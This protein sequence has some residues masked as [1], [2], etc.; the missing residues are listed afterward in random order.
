VCLGEA[1]AHTHAHTHKQTQV[2]PV[3]TEE[4]SSEV[5]RQCMSLYHASFVSAM[6]TFFFLTHK[7][8]F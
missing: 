4:M 1:R 6:T 2:S 7:N 8:Y 5:R 3:S